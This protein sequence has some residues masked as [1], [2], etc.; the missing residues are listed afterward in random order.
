MPDPAASQATVRAHAA[1]VPTWQ[2]FTLPSRGGGTSPAGGTENSDPNHGGG[3]VGG[4]KPPAAAAASAAA[5]AS[6]SASAS[7]RGGG[8]TGN[9]TA[10]NPYLRQY[11]HVYSR[12][13]AALRDRCL[14]AAREGGGGTAATAAATATTT[15]APP[16]PPP[17]VGRILELIEDRPCLLVGTVAKTCKAR[18]PT[19]S[20]YHSGAAA[21][22]Y[23]GTSQPTDLY[24]EPVRTYCS[25]PGEDGEEDRIVLED[26]SGRVEL[27][28]GGGGALRP[29]GLATGA[30]VAVVGTVREGTGGALSVSSVHFPSPP[31]P[32][33]AP[34]G[35]GGG[36]AQVGATASSAAASSSS[37]SSSSSANGDAHVLLISG[38]GCGA[39]GE[40]KG[41]LGL[42]RDLVLDYLAGHTDP[43]RDGARVARVVVAGGGCA[44]PSS[45]AAELASASEAAGSASARPPPV[46]PSPRDA[47]LPIR[48]LDL[49][50]AELCAS[51]IPVDYVPGLHDPTTVVWPQRP[52]HP[53]LLPLSSTYDTM[54][55]RS[56]NPYEARVGGRL[57]LGTDGR[58]V[59]DLRRYLAYDGGGG[60]DDDEKEGGESTSAPEEEAS[61]EAGGG[62]EMDDVDDEGNVI[63]RP[64]PPPSPPSHPRPLSALDA[65]AATLRYCHLAPT[66]PDSLPMYPA[67]EDDPFVLAERPDLY[68]AGNCSEFQTKVVD[69]TRLVC[70]PSFDRTGQAVLVNLRTME[71]EVASFSDVAEEEAAAGDAMEE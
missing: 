61:D 33:P 3:G 26:E 35:E 63:E 64:P 21:G 13:L 71:C 6:A 16:P 62:T 18:P 22:S 12:R 48:E 65:L 5:L 56:P 53:C 14:E 52:L 57:V 39:S 67:F 1:F 40:G 51:G 32:G 59:A 44:L 8:G 17:A 55:H 68:F 50:L 20:V 43:G 31:P 11:S 19:D 70:V 45:V 15:A 27:V 24:L 58:N 38:L 25:P 28:D 7:A 69:G 47:A 46:P 30:V 49:Y 23:L 36:E 66:G 2:R 9:A 29:G 41:S 4:R 34:R 37:S 42:R 60:G 54:L 10:A